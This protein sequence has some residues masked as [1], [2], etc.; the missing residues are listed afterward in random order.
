MTSVNADSDI[1]H[2]FVVP[3]RNQLVE[4]NYYIVVQIREQ[5]GKGWIPACPDSQA[6]L[7][8]PTTTELEA[9]EP[10]FVIK[11]QTSPPYQVSLKV[12]GQPLTMEVDTGT[13]VSLTTESAVEALLPSVQLQPSNVTL[14]TYT[15]ETISIKGTLSVDVDYGQH[16]N[17][18]LKLVIV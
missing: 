6:D 11:D 10:L 13:A 5:G 8:T 12:D 7:T 3:V 9:T 17:R 16:I 1:L 15:G 14:K 4:R 2:L 18:G